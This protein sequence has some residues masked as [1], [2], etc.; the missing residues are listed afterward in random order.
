LECIPA[1]HGVLIAAQ[2]MQRDDQ[3]IL[4]IFGDFGR[5]EHRVGNLLVRVGKKVST[6][7]YTRIDGSA[8]PALSPGRRRSGC[9]RSGRWL[10]DRLLREVNLC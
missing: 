2:S 9:R 5:Y 7:L 10:R 1:H 8:S 6:L 4:L 3:R